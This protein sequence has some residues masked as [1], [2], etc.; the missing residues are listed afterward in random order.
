MKKS[1]AGFLIAFLIPAFCFIGGCQTT[2]NRAKEKKTERVIPRGN[3]MGEGTVVQETVVEEVPATEPEGRFSDVPIPRGF[4]LDRSKTFVYEAGEIKAGSLFYEGAAD[5]DEII[6]F[7]RTE[8]PQF[9][10]KL[11]SIFE[12]NDAT[13]YFEKPGWFCRI[14]IQPAKYRKTAIFVSLGPKKRAE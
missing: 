13:L 4:K 14:Q 3:A 6:S 9:Q 12:T 2:G 10:W 11:M 5:L 8:M 1:F 7:Y